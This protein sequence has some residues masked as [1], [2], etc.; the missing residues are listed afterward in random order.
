MKMKEKRRKRRKGCLLLRRIKLPKYRLC[1]FI[2]GSGA[3]EFYELGNTSDCIN[4]A[5]TATSGYPHSTK[6]NS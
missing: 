6:M 4:A 5:S 1:E 2:N 3:S